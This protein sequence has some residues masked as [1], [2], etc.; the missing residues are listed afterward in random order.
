MQ[1][2]HPYWNQGGCTE[3]NEC[4]HALKEDTLGWNSTSQ[5]RIMENHLKFPAALSDACRDWL[6]TSL[7]GEC[8]HKLCHQL[9]TVPL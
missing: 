5:F 3:L 9:Y 6:H 7:G 4:G 1:C 8:G 2:L